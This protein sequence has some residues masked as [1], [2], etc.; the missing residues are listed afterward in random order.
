ME[1]HSNTNLRGI[2]AYR[3]SLLSNNIYYKGIIKDIHNII[4]NCPI[5]KLKNKILN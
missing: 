2:E 3:N 4:A 5:Y 1:M